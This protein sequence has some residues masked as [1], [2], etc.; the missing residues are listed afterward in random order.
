MTVLGLVGTGLIG[1]SVA[2]AARKY[3]TVN[4]I[5]GLDSDKS[6]IE[7]AISLGII[8]NAIDDLSCLLYTSPSPRD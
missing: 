5:V 1:G 7:R 6:T 4:K 2:L 8:D 3:K